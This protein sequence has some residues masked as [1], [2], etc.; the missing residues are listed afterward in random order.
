MTG[1]STLPFFFSP[2]GAVT[3]EYF[4]ARVSSNSRAHSASMSSTQTRINVALL[5]CIVVLGVMYESRLRELHTRLDNSR[6]QGQCDDVAHLKTLVIETHAQLARFLGTEGASKLRP[7]TGS[8]PARTNGTSGSA[9]AVAV[10]YEAALWVD[11]SSAAPTTLFAPFRSYKCVAGTIP[12]GVDIDASYGVVTWKWMMRWGKAKESFNQPLPNYVSVT[13]S[14][15]AG[16]AGAPASSFYYELGAI[17]YAAE[18]ASG[19]FTVI[20]LGAGWGRWGVHAWM[21]NKQKRDLPAYI[22]GVEGDP[23][24]Y[25]MMRSHYA[26]NGVP[27]ANFMALHAIVGP[28]GDDSSFN[29]LNPDTNWGAGAGEA[30]GKMKIASVTIDEIVSM[31]WVIDHIDIDCQGCEGYIF[32]VPH[33]R[34]IVSERVKS[35]WI[36]CH[37]LAIGAKLDALFTQWGWQV[38]MKI[39]PTP[40]DFGQG[41]VKSEN[42]QTIDLWV[43]NP[44]FGKVKVFNERAT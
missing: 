17:L 6:A 42:E 29:R 26:L 44:K 37:S 34:T 23:Y 13:V 20:E 2:I 36:E 19:T 24:H 15:Q 1:L 11:C 43:A 12:A 8:S 10:G 3:E 21:A 16:Y 18:R 35:M 41:P 38:V 32:D 9:T 28:V 33:V 25:A 14:P 31:F 30:G 40:A 5:L 27:E 22:V 39:T 4:A 7:V